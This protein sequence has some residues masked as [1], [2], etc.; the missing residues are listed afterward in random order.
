MA[1][2]LTCENCPSIDVRR[3]ARLGKLWPAIGF[4]D[5]WTI[6]EEVVCSVDVANEPSSILLSFG[7]W[8]EAISNW[9]N[10]SNRLSIVWSRCALGGRRPWLI[11]PI[12][13]CRKRIAIVYLGQAPVFACRKCHGL[14]Y[15]TQFERIGNRGLERARRIRMAL[16][17]SPNLMDDFPARKGMHRRSYLR[18]KAS[19]EAATMRCGVR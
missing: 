19:Y 3:W 11:C 2:R 12:Q 17:G 6:E 16:G 10:V 14:A 5:S 9:K 7:Y 13:N 4:K 1:G 18:L 8:D 15:A